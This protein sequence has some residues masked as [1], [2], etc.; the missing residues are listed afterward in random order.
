MPQIKDCIWYANISSGQ[1]VGNKCWNRAR[2]ASRY[3]HAHCP[4]SGRISSKNCKDWHSGELSIPAPPWEL[5]EAMDARR[6]ER[7]R[8]LWEMENI[9]DAASNTP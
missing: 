1:I 2:G 7:K 3:S 4:Y 9:G 8:K 6:E 5:V